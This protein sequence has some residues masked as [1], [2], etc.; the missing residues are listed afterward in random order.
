MI[1]S[2]CTFLD[3]YSAFFQVHAYLLPSHGNGMLPILGNLPYMMA[4]EVFILYCI[5][6]DLCCLE[7]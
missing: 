5:Q 4:F 1:Y 2:L 3:F 6:V 7:N